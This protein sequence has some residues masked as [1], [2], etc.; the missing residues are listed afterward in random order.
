M[1]IVNDKQYLDSYLENAIKAHSNNVV[2][3]LCKVKACNG[4]SVD[5]VILSN[6]DELL[7]LKNIPF[8][9]SAYSQP[10]I[11]KDDLGLIFPINNTI[12]NYLIEKENF[13]INNANEYVFMPLVLKSKA[14][15][16]EGNK[17]IITSADSSNIASIDNDLISIQGNNLEASLSE[18]LNAEGKD[19]AIKANN[20]LTINATS[21][22]SAESANISIKSTQPLEIG[23]NDTIGSLVNE[24]ID[25]V[26]ALAP[27]AT[28]L[29]APCTPDPAALVKLTALKA[30]I[31]LSFK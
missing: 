21:S 9:Q 8:I 17:A 26:S 28:S 23:A 27:I 5:I 25:I 4:F 14:L 31:L 1:K 2:C 3:E 10:I 13:Y 18:N 6:D 12:Y 16:G 20:D 22:L 29:G 24:L 15:Q 11:Q 19:I 7:E 30:K